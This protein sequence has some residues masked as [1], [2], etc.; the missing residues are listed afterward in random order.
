MNPNDVIMIHN[1]IKQVIN[2]A[3][4]TVM[5]V[6]GAFSS[7]TTGELYFKRAARQNAN[8]VSVSA[9]QIT[10]NIAYGANVSNLVYLVI[11]NLGIENHGYNVVTLTAS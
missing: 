9:N 3:S 7:N 6:N 11:P 8:V 1:Q 2:I 5:N 10:L 4:A